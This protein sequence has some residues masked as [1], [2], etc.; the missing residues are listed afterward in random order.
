[1]SEAATTSLNATVT[2]V[3]LDSTGT[4]ATLNTPQLGPVA[5]S[6]VQQID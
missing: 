2:S 5:L 6:A 3:T 1:H 4:G